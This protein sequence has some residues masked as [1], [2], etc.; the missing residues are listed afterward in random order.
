MSKNSSSSESPSKKIS[1]RKRKT[2][3]K[4]IFVE[5][6]D[7]AYEALNISKRKLKSGQYLKAFLDQTSSKESVLE[8]IKVTIDALLD[9]IASD[10]DSLSAA[11]L[12]PHPESE[13]P[14]AIVRGPLNRD[15]VKQ[16]L[17]IFRKY[18]PVIND[19]LGSDDELKVLD[20]GIGYVVLENCQKDNYLVG[21][22]KKQKDVDEL[23]RKL[24]HVQNVVID[25]TLL[26][27]G[28]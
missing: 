23:S 14:K 11:A 27:D 19:L 10:L 28:L 8:A 6:E 7:V 22:V 2:T 9:S 20:T 24:R 13:D 15:V 17:S 25:N 3:K 16:I 12:V 21:I 18:P 1:S 4:D 5:M 26:L